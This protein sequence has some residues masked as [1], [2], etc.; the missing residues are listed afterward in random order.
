MNGYAAVSV[1]KRLG[2]KS[3]YE[4]RGLWEVTRASRQKSWEGS[5]HYKLLAKLEA[6]VASEAD[7]VF[8]ITNALANEMERRGVDRNKISKENQVQSETARG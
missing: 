2:V 6:E 3:I 8:C 4:V 1:A 5:Q 7:H